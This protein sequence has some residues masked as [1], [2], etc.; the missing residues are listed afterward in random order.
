[1]S[2][3]VIVIIFAVAVIAELTSRPPPEKPFSQIIAVGP[4]WDTTSWVC[5]SS[6]NYMIY[7]AI[8]GIHGATYA[9]AES[10]LGTQSLYVTVPGQME[11]FA[12]GS[13]GGQTITITRDGTM[14]GYI[15][16]Q[17]TEGAQASC[18]GK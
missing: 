5:T 3:A 16:L 1:M 15:T 9:I 17:T 10:Q 6:S 11:T 7:G 12:V 4:L 18:V 13:P 14:T 8:R 2:V